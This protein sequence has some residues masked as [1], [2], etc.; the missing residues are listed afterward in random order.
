MN[1]R[2]KERPER[3]LRWGVIGLSVTQPES[4]AVVNNLLSQFAEGED[5]SDQ[6]YSQKKV[7]DFGIV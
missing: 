5:S 6:Q 3:A 7:D 2:G 1:E 4:V